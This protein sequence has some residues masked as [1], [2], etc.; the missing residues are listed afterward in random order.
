MNIHETGTPGGT[1]VLPELCV[2]LPGDMA[3]AITVGEASRSFPRAMLTSSSLLRAPRCLCCPVGSES[4]TGSVSRHSRTGLPVDSNCVR[5]ETDRELAGCWVVPAGRVRSVQPVV[6][7]GVFRR[8]SRERCV[9]GSG[10]ERPGCRRC[11]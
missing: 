4:L 5:V 3:L 10:V 9:R 11:A 7:V 6:G 2:R 8:P 1:Y